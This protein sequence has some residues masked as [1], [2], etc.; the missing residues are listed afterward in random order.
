MCVVILCYP[1]CDITVMPNQSNSPQ[2]T[3][4]TEPTQDT[5]NS[6]SPSEEVSEMPLRQS[7]RIQNKPKYLQDCDQKVV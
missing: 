4:P 5:D 3:E 6:N 7:S 2:T 1:G